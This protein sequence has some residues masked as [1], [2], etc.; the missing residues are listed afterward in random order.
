MID[1]TTREMME[2][3]R[4]SVTNNNFLVRT[5][6]PHETTHLAEKIE[7]DVKK[8]GR[9]MAPFVS[10]RRGGKVVTR[11]GFHTNQIHT[12]KLAPERLVTTDDLTKRGFGENVYTAK[13]PEEREDELLAQDALEMQEMIDRRIEW[14]AAKVL[15]TGGFDV[16]DEKEGIDIHVDYNF[17]NQEVLSGTAKWDN[18]A[19]DPDADLLKWSLA[20][21]KA[22]GV[23]PDIL[24]CDSKT[25]RLYLN[26][27]KVIAKANILN[28]NDTRIEPKII[29]PNVTFH[30]RIASLGLDLYSYDEWID[31]ESNPGMQVLPYG[32]VM[33]A[34]SNGVGGVH[35]GAVTQAEQGQG[36][37]TYEAK[38]V[39]KHIVDEN[40]D[41]EKLRMTSRPLPAPDDVDSWAVLVV[42]S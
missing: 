31:D 27:A 21:T 35:Y 41:I 14:M 38:Y 1:Y 25:M 42:A 39:P 24:L 17:T 23:K 12:P 29:D 10:P 13:S 26:H 8:G 2:A 7:V 16:V 33:L 5:F 11:E 34:N 4:L 40:D 30:G 3:I 37:V 19:S 36:F 18:E 20:V 28:V 22:S 32:T 6:F 9:K 15:T